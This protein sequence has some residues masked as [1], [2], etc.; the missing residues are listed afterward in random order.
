[1]SNKLLGFD[2]HIV[3]IE[4]ISDETLEMFKAKRSDIIPKTS[5]IILHDRQLSKNSKFNNYYPKNIYQS[6]YN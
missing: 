1:M 5:R 6:N 3:Q 4:K 2:T